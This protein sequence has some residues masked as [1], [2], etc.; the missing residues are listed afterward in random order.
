MLVWAKAGAARA[1]IVNKGVFIIWLLIM[2]ETTHCDRPRRSIFAVYCDLRLASP[3]ASGCA[4]GRL[5]IKQRL[6]KGGSVWRNGQV[7]EW[8]KPTDCK[9]VPPCE[10]RRFESFPVHQSF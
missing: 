9:S 7:G 2:T 6:A 4:C 5:S 10:V 8:L 3:G 1:R